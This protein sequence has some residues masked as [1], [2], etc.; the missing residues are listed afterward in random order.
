MTE[1]TGG[2][3][4]AISTEA[5]ESIVS[6]KV[7]LKS[8]LVTLESE[9]KK[10]SD[11]LASWEKKYHDLESGEADRTKIAIS[12]ARKSW[13]ADL[14]ATAEKE[15]AVNDLK[16]VMSAEAAESYLATNPTVDQIKSIAGIMKVQASKG[17]GVSSS[18]NNEDGKSFDELNSIWNSRL[19]RS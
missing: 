7:E 9:K 16:S 11:E 15:S 2:G 12:E 4:P 17:V 14:K 13:E 6:E 10:L 19:G 3:T 1:K 8:Q 18:S 5:Y